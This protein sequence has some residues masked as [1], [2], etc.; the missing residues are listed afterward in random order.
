M[1]QNLN[2]RGAKWLLS[3]FLLFASAS[4][5]QI[6]VNTSLIHEYEVMRGQEIQLN[7]PIVNGDKWDAEI[8]IFLQDVGIEN[9]GL[10]MFDPG[11]IPRSAASFF[12]PQ[13]GRFHLPMGQK[14][15]LKFVVK[16]PEILDPGSYYVAV[17]IRPERFLA[18][19]QKEARVGFRIHTEYVIQYIFTIPGEIDFEIEETRI[20][21]EA[22]KFFVTVKNTGT[23]IS[24]ISIIGDDSIFKLER[25]G[26][27]PGGT[28]TW[29]YD[30]S[31]LPFRN[32]HERILLDDG[33]SKIEIEEVEFEFVEKDAEAER[34]A[35][36][37]L[38]YLEEEVV[39]RKGRKREFANAS[40]RLF[41]GSYRRGFNILGNVNLAK[42]LRIT[43]SSQ[44]YQPMLGITDEFSE[45]F[46]QGYRIGVRFSPK[47][48]HAGVSKY[49]FQDREMT[50]GNIG[51]N[52]KNTNI[53][54]N[55]LYEMEILSSNFSQKIGPVRFN[56]YGT[57][58][59]NPTMVLRH[60]EVSTNIRL[61]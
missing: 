45:I 5:A 11:S 57:F 52:F 33:K 9:E 25:K 6:T 44:A 1:K 29:E 55:Y 36:L 61:F 46:L 60:F 8:S 51:L 12:T 19:E 41:W 16:I 58:D 48:F 18:E 34:L 40:I 13:A 49:I 42:N 39:G 54:L 7:I 35:S 23:E 22:K 37:S 31:D 26:I 10:V 21:V 20:D 3:L 38:T 30:L 59:V 56:F 24:K 47:N 2:L 32:Y 14:A 17:T 50:M 27:F 53:S 28:R 15:D 4:E 43:G